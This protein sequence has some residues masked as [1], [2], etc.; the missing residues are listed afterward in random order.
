MLVYCVVCIDAERIVI[1]CGP[2]CVCVFVAGARR[3]GQFMAAGEFK[4]K[5]LPVVSI[6]FSEFGQ[7][8]SASFTF[9]DNLTSEKDS[10]N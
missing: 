3:N 10:K 6:I 5:I 7:Q 1:A 9:D 8:I 2:V 4:S